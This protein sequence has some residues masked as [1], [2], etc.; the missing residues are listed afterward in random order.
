ML[1][2]VEYLMPIYTAKFQRWARYDIIP[3]DISFIK[4]YPGS[5]IELC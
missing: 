4:Q 1:V 3:I 2:M 5:V